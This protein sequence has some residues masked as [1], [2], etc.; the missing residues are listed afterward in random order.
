MTDFKYAFDNKRYHTWNYYL[1]SNFGEKVFKVSIN[2][3]FSCPNID[4]TI[5]YGGC[6]YC[7]KEGSGDFAGN[8]ND[9]LIKQFEDIKQMMHKKWHSAKYI[10][11]FQAFTNTHAPVNI[12]KEKYETILNLE[13]V[14]GLSISTRPDCLPDD[15]VEYLAKLNKKTNLWVELGLQTI[16]D[17]TSK[18]IN[19]GHDYDTFLE[20]VEKL[21]KHN[22]KTVVHIINGLPG[23]DYNMMMETA[24]AVSEL[25]VHG[26][27]IHLLHVL[28]NTPMEKM[29]EKEMF[30]LMEKDEYVNLVCDQL[31]ILPPEMVVHRLT[32]DGKRDEMVGPMWSLKK[33]EVLNAIDDTMKK[34]NSYQG[35]K[36]TKKNNA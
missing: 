1:R 27:K 24:K 32:G 10:G 28:K 30:T 9:N 22:I 34:R 20:G 6:T 3:G 14:I 33:W 35:I 21:K 19:R 36:Y 29:L 26:I 17:K 7:S 18:V 16:H 5:T 2:A 13:D 23:E 4:G 11:Y 8:P 31:E 25:G 15:V 12:L